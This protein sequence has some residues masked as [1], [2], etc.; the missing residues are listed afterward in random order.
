MNLP[1]YKNITELLQSLDAPYDLGSSAFNVSQI[2]KKKD[3]GITK[4]AHRTDFYGI[5]FIKTGKGTMCVNEH[6]FELENN[7][8]IFT[9]PGQII[10]LE[11]DYISNGYCIFFMPEF[12]S[13]KFAET[14]EKQFPFFKFNIDSVPKINITN[15][16]LRFE[17]LF[18]SIN[19]E[20]YKK[21]PEYLGVIRSYLQV[22]LNL[23]NR[24]FVQKMGI[25]NYK[26]KNHE[27][28]E[29]L[30]KLVI[31]YMPERKN[32]AYLA[33]KLSISS[34]HLNAIVKEITGKTTTEF[35]VSIFMI[36]AKNLLMHS[37][38]SITEVAY[39]LNFDDPSYFNK[40]FKKQFNITPLDFKKQSGL[41]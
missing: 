3:S 23:T 34:K 13:L 2:R 27:L 21:E 7:M 29:D 9:S 25:P 16:S 6:C 5:T 38:L 31:E 4:E 36:E 17:T 15:D 30:R 10:K 14:V 28:V 12:L 22:V 1:I 40:V 33:E 41:P 8:L 35:I 24:F 19:M 20:N 32:I 11:V 18:I 37:N 26:N 39:Q